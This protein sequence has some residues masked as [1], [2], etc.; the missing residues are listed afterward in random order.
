M[1]PT[2]LVTG[3]AWRGVS[4]HVFSTHAGSRLVLVC[5]S[6]PLSECDDM[7]EA[8]TWEAQRVDVCAVSCC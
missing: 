3:R 8:M 1:A 6:L 7:G 4:A 5:L 2:S